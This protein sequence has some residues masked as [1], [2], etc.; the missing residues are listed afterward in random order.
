MVQQPTLL[1]GRFLLPAVHP[2]PHF[3]EEEG[4]PYKHERNM[5]KNQTKRPG[6]KELREEEEKKKDW[7]TNN[8][9]NL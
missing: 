1:L 6:D 4:E 7:I 3:M 9:R 5:T 2:F 8:F